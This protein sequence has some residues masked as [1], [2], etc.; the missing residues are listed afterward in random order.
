MNVNG[1]DTDTRRPAKNMRRR[2]LQES[3]AEAG[4]WWCRAES[5]AWVDGDEINAG[6]KIMDVVRFAQ[7]T[8][9]TSAHGG[10]APARL[11]YG[12]PSEH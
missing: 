10:V 12:K 6:N 9:G 3:A 7:L 4:R 8:D 5:V 1:A 11:S 2:S